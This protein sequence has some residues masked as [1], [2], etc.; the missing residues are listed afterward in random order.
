MIGVMDGRNSSA[1]KTNQSRNI[2]AVLFFLGV[3][4]FRSY[5]ETG[6][7]AQPSYFGLYVGWHHV[8]WMLTIVL[9][10][11]LLAHG[12]LR[13]PVTRLLWLMYGGVVMLMPLLYGLVTGKPLEMD[14]LRGSPIELL[15]HTVSF[16]VTYQPNR[17][18][19]IELGT[20]FVCMLAVGYG[21]SRSLLKPLLL[22]VAV[23][24][25]GSMLAVDWMG[26]GPNSRGLITVSTRLTH[27]PM[28]SVV[29]LHVVTVLVLIAISRAQKGH[30]S[31]TE[32]RQVALQVFLVWLCVSVLLRLS[33]WSAKAFD[34][35]VCGLPF[36]SLTLLLVHPRHVRQGKWAWADVCLLSLVA[37][38]FAVMLPIFLHQEARFNPFLN[39]PYTGYGP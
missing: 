30:A 24:V 12:I 25:V 36:A 39:A 9:S 2:L 14:Y 21:Y 38:Q 32:R 37:L 31:G 16:C 10:I 1:S 20:I 7:F 11:I 26:T 28:M 34:C 19:A 6:V 18:L 13:V 3:S 35:V 27:H 8:L 23:Q 15:K 22:A 5:M 17:P 33:S 4:W 29:L